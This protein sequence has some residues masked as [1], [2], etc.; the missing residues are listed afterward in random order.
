MKWSLLPVALLALIGAAPRTVDAARLPPSGASLQVPVGAPWFC[1]NLDCPKFDVVET[2]DDYEV[3]E[4]EA[5]SWVS[6][7][8]EAYAYALAINKAFQ[9]LYQYIDG[10]NADATKIPMT[11]PVRTKISAA[12]G[13]FCKNNFTVSFFVPFAFQKKGA[14]KPNNPDLYLEDAPAST[15]YVAQKGGYVMD[16]WSVQ[17]MVKALSDALERDE[18][19]YETEVFYVAGYDPPFRITG[20]HNEVWLEAKDDKLSKQ[21]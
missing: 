1:H 9:Q 19:D 2:T 15:F 12:S 3:R 18:K 6:M 13:P 5:G 21:Q 14:P 11:A 4:Y 16:D 8:V 7:D 20:R 10:A 17:K